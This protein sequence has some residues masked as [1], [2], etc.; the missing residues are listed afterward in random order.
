[1]YLI[2]GTPLFFGTGL[3]LGLYLFLGSEEYLNL[4]TSLFLGTDLNFGV[5]PSLI[6][7]EKQHGSQCSFN[8]S[9]IV[10]FECNY[11]GI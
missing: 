4:G 11:L 6:R 5:D 7:I 2:L 8:L 9:L 3:Y 10:T 1:M